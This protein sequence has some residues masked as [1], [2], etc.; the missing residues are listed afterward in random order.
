MQKSNQFSAGNTAAENT[1]AYELTN[2]C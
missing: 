2:V 1:F